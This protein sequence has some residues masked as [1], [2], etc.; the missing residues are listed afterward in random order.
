LKTKRRLK[1]ARPNWKALNRL[2]EAGISLWTKGSSSALA[3]FDASTTSLSVPTA[4]IF[5]ASALAFSGELPA[6]FS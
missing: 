4:L 3:D 2:S 6:R 5:F 1:V